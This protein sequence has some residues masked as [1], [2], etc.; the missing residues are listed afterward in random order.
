MTQTISGIHHVTALAIDPQANIDFYT[1]VLGLRLVKQTVNFDDPSVYHFYYGDQAGSP[2]TILTFFPFTM[3]AR[4]HAGPGMVDGVTFAVATEALEGWMLRLAEHAVEF[5]GPFER[6]GSQTIAFRDPDGLLLEIVGVS[7]FDGAATLVGFDAVTLCVEV[8]DLTARLLTETFGYRESGEDGE[9]MRFTAAGQGAP[10]RHID[11][12][13][14]TDATRRKPGGG[15]VH[16]VAFRARND[17]ELKAWREQIAHLGFNVTEIR[18]R[19]YFHSIYFREPGGILFEVATDPPG[20]AVD[21]A[22]AALG[23]SLKLP[24][25]LEDQREKI[26]QR[27]PPVR[28]P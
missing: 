6:F 1:R 13:C 22:P 23:T 19:N 8:P 10:G 12:M 20:F 2:G 25:W 5:E 9:R 15:T 7:G 4:G 24:S 14:R 3:A 11:I 17:D 28:L 27:L 16:H 21:E 18:D 26:V